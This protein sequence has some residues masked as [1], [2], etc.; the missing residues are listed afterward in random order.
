[1]PTEDIPKEDP[2]IPSKL[3][4]AIKA[5][6]KISDIKKS[7]SKDDNDAAMTSAVWYEKIRAAVEYQEAHLMF[8]SAVFRIMQRNV[9][10]NHKV[11]AERLF[12]NVVNELTWANYLNPKIFND[13][14][15]GA[16]VTLTLDKY[17][18]IIRRSNSDHQTYT[19]LVRYFSGLC[20][21]EVEELIFS[22]EADLKFLEFVYNAVVDNFKFNENH[23]HAVDHE[24]QL[25]L[26][27]Y[28]ILVKP[29]FNYLSYNALKLVYPSWRNMDEQKYL[30]LTKNIDQFMQSYECQI[31]FH[32]RNRYL[33]AF[34]NMAAPFSV[35]RTYFLTSNI[36]DEWAE[37]NPTMLEYNLSQAYESLRFQS[38]LKIWRGIWRALI[39]IFC[40]KM[41]LAFIIE[42][43]VD[44]MIHGSILWIPLIANISFPPL[45]M[46]VSGA[47]IPKIPTGNS[48]LMKESIAD[49]VRTGKL[50]TEKPV[51]IEIKKKTAA[52][53]AFNFVLS[54]Y[55]IG[56]LAFVVWLLVHFKFSVVSILL[57]FLFVSAVSFLSFRIRVNSKELLVRRRSQDS[58]TTVVEFFFLPFITLG[59]WMSDRLNRLNPILLAIDFIIEAPFKTI[60][61]IFR[62]WFNFISSKKDELEY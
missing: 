20:A 56:I 50:P 51:L 32:L 7:Q 17:L 41:I 59:K 55:S 40:S 61:K 30:P 57:F 15:L 19:E 48:E 2:N 54:V 10:L 27:I 21:C 12:N 47:S 3:A 9:L 6:A 44:K 11:K 38:N 33:L 13:E 14:K 45:L 34:R 37:K 24:I 35:M 52:S 25:K 58:I 43:P 31:T 46:F 23:I 28:T 4:K 36:D 60:I 49:I 1:M 5:Y 39:F 22:K 53:S 62:T 8:K 42:I 16:E 29:D 18:K 26:A